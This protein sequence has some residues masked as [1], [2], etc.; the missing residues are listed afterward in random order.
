MATIDETTRLI[1]TA[2]PRIESYSLEDARAAVDAAER[3]ADQGFVQEY[4]ALITKY[5]RRLVGEVVLRSGVLPNV[6]IV[7]DRL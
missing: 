3:L 4:E 1:T 6:R 2:H 7:I 5:G